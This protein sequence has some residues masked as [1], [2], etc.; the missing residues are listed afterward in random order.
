MEIVAEAG[1]QL[2]IAIAWLVNLFHPS[3]IVIGGD[4]NVVRDDML[5]AVRRSASAHSIPHASFGVPIV[6]TELE[7]Y[8]ELHGAVLV[9]MQS[10]QLTSREPAKEV[11][12][13]G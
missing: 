13:A 1:R 2:G 11:A 12:G 6:T 8:S 4:L 7:L 10:Q 9:A 3:L 5:H